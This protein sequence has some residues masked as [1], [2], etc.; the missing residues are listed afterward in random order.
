MKDRKLLVTVAGLERDF[1]L[2]KPKGL[3][4]WHIKFSPPPWVR[5]KLGLA[6]VFRSCGTSHVPSAKVKAAGIVASYWPDARNNG[7]VSALLEAELKPRGELAALP[8]YVERYLN[9]AR[10]IENKEGLDPDTIKANVR[11]LLVIVETRFD[12]AGNRIRRAGS[13]RTMRIDDALAPDL[14]NEFKTGWLRGVDQDNR[15]AVDRAKRTVN[16]YIAQGRSLFAEDYLPL[17]KG[18]R[19]PDL[20]EFRKVKRFQKTGS[21][22]YVPVSDTV[23]AQ[24]MSGIQELR[25][26]RPDLYLGFCFCLFLGMRREEVIEARLEWIEQWPTGAVMALRKRAYYEPKGIDGEVG[27]AP[28]L[29][30]D[31]RELSGAKQPMDYLIPASSPTARRKAIERRLSKF[32]RRYIGKDRI[33]T[34]HTLRKHG[35]C[36][37]LM[38]DYGQAV[39]FSRHADERTFRAHYEGFLKPPVVIEAATMAGALRALP[40]LTEPRQ[41]AQ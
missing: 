22:R 28:W 21:T 24:M 15:L 33:K 41:A 4:D 3:G 25:T 17:Y 30:N 20:A 26:D 35:C 1:Y 6:V 34:L 27:I 12:A 32:V 36:L 16:S 10:T 23:I 9:G 40:D 37:A 2:L 5:E 8:E 11:A 19:L 29:L 18:L 31:I 38:Q 13:W 7:Q 14:W 39:R